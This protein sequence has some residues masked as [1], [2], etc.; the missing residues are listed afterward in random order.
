[1]PGL[2]RRQNARETPITLRTV[3]YLVS[4]HDWPFLDPQHLPSNRQKTSEAVLR[5]AWEALGPAL[6][7][8][9]VQ[10]RPC[11][12]PPG[13]W[14]FASTHRRRP[15][16]L[17]RGGIEVDLDYTSPLDNAEEDLRPRACQCRHLRRYRLL[18]QAE[19]SLMTTAGDGCPRRRRPLRQPG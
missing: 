6:V 10:Y 1:M 4:G 17:E 2:A 7:A 8:L 11:S 18:T 16:P 12:R 19:Q 9:Y 13:F 3:E 5:A 14:W 15:R